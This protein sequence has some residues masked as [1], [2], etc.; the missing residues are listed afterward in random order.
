MSLLK[1][2]KLTLLLLLEASGASSWLSGTAW[3]RNRLL[4]LCYHGVARYDEADWDPLYLPAATFR[5][6]M[7]MVAEAGCTVLPLGEALERLHSRTLPERA[8]AITFDDGF[9]DFYQVALPVL[10]SFGY[11][12][13]L[14]LTTYYV[15]YNRPVFDPMVG[16]LLWKG[17][18]KGILNWPEVS[19]KPFNLDKPGRVEAARALKQFALDR[20]ISGREKD[21]LLARLAGHL[22]VD[23]EELC[24]RRMLHLVSPE[25]AADMSARGVDLELHTHRHRE[26]RGRV[27]MLGELEDNR[28][29]LAEFSPR[30]PRHFCYTGGMHLPQYPD[31]LKSY[32]L[33]SATTCE[34]GLCEV[35]TN[36]YL[37]PRLVDTQ[38]L[39]DLEFRSWLAGTPH[40]L[41]TRPYRPAEGQLLE[42][43]DPAA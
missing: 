20:K 31:Y 43:P 8:V 25:E 42:D 15:D 36:P 9:L 19:T 10:E 4:I 37:L 12:V 41:P 24:Q 1:K 29:R 14:Y 39:T 16:Y 34:S 2:G 7:E 26:Y 32:G 13:T 11:P 33:I 27:R 5:R 23:Y 6:R 3:R 38:T 30:E 17:R 18:E 40:F 21:D 22:G 28:R 35:S